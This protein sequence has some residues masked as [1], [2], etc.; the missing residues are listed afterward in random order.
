MKIVRYYEHGGPEVLRVEEAPIPQPEAEQILLQVEAIDVG[1]IDSQ[2]RASALWGTLTFPVAPGGYVYGRVVK[3]GSGVEE[4]H[5]GDH[6]LGFAP[7]GAYAEY[8]LLPLA[9][10]ILPLPKTTLSAEELVTLPV[11]GET[12]YHLL[13]TSARLQPGESI[14]IH[15]AAGGVMHLALQLARAM[16]AGQI[17]ATA[18][19]PN[20]LTFAQELGAD[21][22]INYSEP[23]WAKQVEQATGGKGVDVILDAIGDQILLESLPL[24]APF[25]RLIFYGLVSGRLPAI[26]PESLAGLMLGS[27]RFQGFSIMTLMQQHPELIARGREELYR[28]VEREEVRPRITRTFALADIAEAHRWLEARASYGKIVMRP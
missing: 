8:A 21:V 15:A 17:I 3:V 23:N 6:L 26:P 12:A 11:S 5:E 28:Y 14:L 25:G 22:L 16:G 7:S 2:V 18:S 10:R 4:I 19:S 1:Y 24:L 27:K 9:N 13:A 20:K